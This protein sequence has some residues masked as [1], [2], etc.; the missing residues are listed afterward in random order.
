MASSKKTN[1]GS[2]VLFQ[3]RF[4]VIRANIF[5]PETEET[6]DT[7]ARSVTALTTAC[8][9]MDSYAPADL[10]VAIRSISRPLISAMSSERSRLSG[11][12][13]DLVAVVASCLGVAFDPLLA[14][15][16]PVLLVLSSRTS[17]VT[18]ARARTCIL[19]VIEATHL[20]NILSHLMQSITDKSVSLRLTI[21]ES[22]LACM[23][24]F[25][26][27]DLEKDARAKEIEVIIRTTARDANA[28]VRKV[29]RKVFEAYKL[30]LP[31]RLES[32]TMPLT[33]TTRKYLDIQSK[34]LKPSHPLA[35][36]KSSQLSSSTS[37]V[38][39]PASRRPQTHARSASSPA[40]ALDV[41]ASGTINEK[42][43]RSRVKANMA[44][45]KLPE[46]IQT[47]RPASVA[48][49][50]SAI[51][52]KRVVSMSAAVRPVV[53]DAKPGAPER[54]RPIPVSNH[55]A[56][57][58]QPDEVRQPAQTTSV[59]ARR[60]PI[61]EAQLKLDAEKAIRARPR[62]D[63]SV[64]TPAMRQASAATPA[65]VQASKPPIPRA[66]PNKDGAPAN[67][68]MAKPKSRDPTKQRSLTQ[69]TLSQ[70][71]RAKT[72]ERRVPVPTVPR[73][74]RGKTAPR[75]AQVPTSK[76]E[77][78]PAPPA[79]VTP[80]PDEPTSPHASTSTVI[81]P[82]D[83]AE[84]NKEDNTSDREG[85]D[86]GSLPRQETLQ[87][88]KPNGE[89]QARV[90]VTEAPLDPSELAEATTPPKVERDNVASSKTPISELL[91]SIERGFLFTPSAPLSPPQSYLPLAPPA[92]LAIPFPLWAGSEQTEESGEAANKLFEG[93]RRLESRRALG[94]VAIN[95]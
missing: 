73:P 32:F 53:P 48:R 69:P 54:E 33:P 15:F 65:L 55:A 12:A 82:Q 35:H 80:A 70:I 79:T 76:G 24:C 43:P 34:A 5:L 92:N 29:S 6:W 13:I 62:I 83:T 36:S 19:S 89:E 4:D 16:F 50:T 67:K 57:R 58:L 41:G 37:A 74:L 51:D 85:D 93:I 78:Q 20:P 3:D 1:L 18:V 26:P 63:N 61:S 42:P 87:S 7:I 17:K 72:I 8:N 81:T 90:T 28:D 47:S 56:R 68:V 64:S 22:T 91:L 59:V 14:H 25:N 88:E 38:R 49:P 75:K 9:D 77:Q 30:L 10:V 27:P 40:V 71:S 84:V 60:V 44:P 39:G 86:I 95:K 52:R 2:D 46:A 45:P 21:V 23:N 11:V 66:A 31:S 94:D